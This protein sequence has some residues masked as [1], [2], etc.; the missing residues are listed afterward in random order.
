MCNAATN[1]EGHFNLNRCLE[2]IVVKSVTFEAT[3]TIC[4]HVFVTCFLL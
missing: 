4:T 1:P 2:A 3:V